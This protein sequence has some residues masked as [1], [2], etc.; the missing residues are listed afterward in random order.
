MIDQLLGALVVIIPLTFII[1]LYYAHQLRWAPFRHLVFGLHLAVSKKY[2]QGLFSSFAALAGVL[3]G[4]LGVGNIAGIAVALK[5]GGPGSIFWMWVMAILGASIKMVGCVLGVHYRRHCSNIGYHGGPMYYIRDGLKNPFLAKVFCLVTIGAA[6]TVGNMA[7]VNSFVLSIPFFATGGLDHLVPLSIVALAGSPGIALAAIFGI[8]VSIILGAIFMGGVKRFAIISIIFVPFT[9]LIYFIACLLV[10]TI[11]YDQIW[12]S[13]CLIVKSSFGLSAVAGG[14]GG[15][16][17]MQVIQVGF[18][19]GLF[20]TDA[21]AGLE[22]MIHAT[23]SSVRD[24][25]PDDGFK[26]GL[27]SAIAPIIVVFL[28]TLTALVLLV[29]GVWADPNLSSSSMCIAAFTKILGA[30]ANTCMCIIIGCF[31]ITTIMTWSFCCDRAVEFLLGR[32]SCLG[33]VLFL[34]T[35]PLGA[36]LH[37]DLVWKLGDLAFNSMLLINLAA[38]CLLSKT[39][40]PDLKQ[41]IFSLKP[42]DNGKKT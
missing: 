18:N 30:H 40:M 36:I 23:V 2:N 1:G 27:I 17:L 34:I 21:G 31:A 25:H 9:A 38:V 32:P 16:S 7:Q 41:W 13:L 22:A 4:N 6:L 28:C 5:M 29:T 42:I 26:Q 15:Y 14:V 20:A 39:I 11:S 33:K 12:P 8:G 3:G 19:R 35:I 37:V 24:G 10:L